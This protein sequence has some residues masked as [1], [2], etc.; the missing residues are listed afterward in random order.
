[1]A[2][3]VVS[4]VIFLCGVLVGRGVRA[5]RGGSVETALAEPVAAEVPTAAASGVASSAEP[6]PEAPRPV[7]ED[8]T[9]FNRLD[10]SNPPAEALKPPAAARTKPEPPAPPP[11]RP[12]TQ[13]PVTPAA[14]L[15]LSA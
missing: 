9:Y 14:P 6:P 15:P 5:E 1:M 8:L 2:A 10:Q 12:A 13:E 7:A 4:V 11:S 3:T